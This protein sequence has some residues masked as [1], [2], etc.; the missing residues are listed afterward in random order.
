MN[1]ILTLNA[2]LG[3]DL[4]PDFDLSVNT[5]TITPNN[6]NLTDLLDGILVSVDDAAT[7]ITI[8]STGACTNSL[9]LPITS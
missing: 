2:G 1:V 7:S 3:V 8:T 5:G 6:S 9:I 4:G